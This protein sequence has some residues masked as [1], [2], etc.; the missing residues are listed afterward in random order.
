MQ[1]KKNIVLLFPDQLRADFLGCYG[2]RFIKT[3]NIDALCSD[4]VRYE[5]A[6]SPSPVCIP[7]RA[8]MLTGQ[9][10]IKTGVFHNDQWLRPDHNA[11]GMKTWAQLLYEN[12][13]HTEAIGKMHFYPW[14]IKEGFQHRVIA[15][16]KRHIYIEDDYYRYLKERGYK[17][18][19]ISELDG[20]IKNKGAAV[21][22]IPLEHQ[23]DKWV[24]DRTCEFIEN[25]D[26]EAPFVLMAGFPGPHCPYDPPIEMADR[27][28]PENMPDSLPATKE[29]LTFMRECIEGNKLSWNGVD[30]SEFTKS[31]KKRV[32]AYYAALVTIID[33]QTGR[34]MESLRKKNLIKDTIVIF[35][36]DHGDYLGDYGMIGKKE[37]YESCAHIPMIVK[38]PGLGQS[39]AVD[40]VVS[41]T[42]LY[43][44][45]LDFAGLS[46]N[47]GN[48]D[49]IVLPGLY[50]KA[51]KKREYLFA[52][53]LVGFM[54]VKGPYKYCRYYNGVNVLFNI[55]D[56][57]GEQTNLLNDP[58]YRNIAAELD[59][60]MLEEIFNSLQASN[61]EKIVNR[62]GIMGEGNFGKRNWKRTY[63]ANETGFVSHQAVEIK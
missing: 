61:S 28:D 1:K 3:P 20:G 38:Y 21:S 9:N 8:S 32:R 36:S 35:A 16:D 47:R 43:S 52:P 11:C 62:G 13:Y 37:F 44:T 15:E 23:V 42:D 46:Y 12:G 6:L 39:K 45:I 30:Y 29:S 10:C 22:K 51:E 33:Q 5:R 59:Q 19:H 25:Y 26:S 58:D 31:Q 60:I 54:V 34:I 40:S 14:D 7:A 27:Y 2:A 50:H 56:D 57:P 48:G 18:Y 17:K 49:S 63:P 53:S 4:G 24:G 55:E 41:L